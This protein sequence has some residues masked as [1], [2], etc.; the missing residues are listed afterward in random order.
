MAIGQYELMI[1]NKYLQDYPVNSFEEL[2]P[3]GKYVNLD[4]LLGVLL[5]LFNKSMEMKRKEGYILNLLVGISTL[6]D[7][8]SD[9]GYGVDEEYINQIINIKEKYA[10]YASKHNISNDKINAVIER[11]DSFVFI[12]DE[13]EKEETE[14]NEPLEEE[15][16]EEKKQKLT[17]SITSSF[18]S[19]NKENADLREQVLKLKRDL[20]AANKDTKGIQRR[21]DESERRVRSLKDEKRAF[22]KKA[23]SLENSLNQEKHVVEKKNKQ[24]ESSEAENA[25]LKSKLRE[26]D[27]L[28]IEVAEFK[29]REKGLKTLTKSNNVDVVRKKVLRAAISLLMEKPMSFDDLERELAKKELLVDRADLF[30][31]FK[32]I[33]EEY[34]VVIDT[35]SKDGAP[36]YSIV[37]PKHECYKVTSIKR[38]VSNILLTSDWHAYDL[39]DNHLFNRV[40]ML[41]EY[42]AKYGISMTVNLGDFYDYRLNGGLTRA[43]NSI[44]A[45][46]RLES[47]LQ[48][49]PYQNGM[50]H[51]LLGANHDEIL[52]RYRLSTLKIIEDMRPDYISLGHNHAIL[53]INGTPFGLHHPDAKF[54][55]LKE[56]KR[57]LMNF[58]NDNENDFNSEDMYMNIFGH[59]H[60]YKFFPLEGILS[61]PSLTRDFRQDGAIHLHIEYDADGCVSQVEIIPLNARKSLKRQKAIVYQKKLTP[62]KQ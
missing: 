23:T 40:E 10:E 11:I 60:E 8:L 9:C 27:K 59:F 52:R 20:Y 46:N 28:R 26:L 50:T 25:D 3:E 18:I 5:K 49:L 31:I 14:E 45:K 43:Q 51:Y 17:E 38:P 16:E 62:K 36:L 34:E 54:N 19:L 22:E 6:V 61:C 37:S 1:I 42:C 12:T 41:L 33:R 58:S 57:G 47:I 44:D 7:E 55:N 13:K 48:K 4:E 24:L 53:D 56:Y 30:A 35:S 32:D 2:I 29:K 39:D 15:S 21:L